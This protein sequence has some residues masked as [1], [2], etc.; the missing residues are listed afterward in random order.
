MI[1]KLNKSI[2]LFSFI[3]KNIHKA[4]IILLLLSINYSCIL[5]IIVFFIFFN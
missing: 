5:P 4:V 3:N 1:M 2:I